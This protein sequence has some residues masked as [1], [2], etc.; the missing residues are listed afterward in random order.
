LDNVSEQLERVE[1]VVAAGSEKLIHGV[2]N[3]KI[4]QDYSTVDID[5]D[6]K[7]GDTTVHRRDITANG[8]RIKVLF[9]FSNQQNFSVAVTDHSVKPLGF[10]TADKFVLAPNGRYSWYVESDI[11]K[12]F[13]FITLK[14]MSARG[15]MDI[16]V[17][18][19]INS[20]Q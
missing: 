13:L 14:A 3:I 8:T 6:F 2:F 18:L 7:T 4:L 10:K 17:K 9:K 12:R 16:L 19:S 20:E 5:V 11:P 1:E 15:N